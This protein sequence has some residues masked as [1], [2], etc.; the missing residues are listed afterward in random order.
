M[1]LTQNTSIIMPGVKCKI[2]RA[3]HL[4]L[5]HPRHMLISGVKRDFFYSVCFKQDGGILFQMQ[6]KGSATQ[7]DCNELSNLAA[8]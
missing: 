6:L 4:L 5:D 1:T 3:V 7:N 2:V 8:F